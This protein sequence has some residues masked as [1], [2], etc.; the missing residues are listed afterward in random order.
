[1][2]GSMTTIADR[3]SLVEVALATAPPDLVLSNARLV[4]VL[5]R[6]ITLSDIA[7]KNGRI[8]AVAPAGDGNW[9]DCPRLDLGTR[10]VAPGFIDAH[11]HVESSMVTVAEYAKAAVAHGVTMI[12]ADPHEIGNVLGIAG[13]KLMF[14]EAKTVPLRVRLRVPGRIPAMPDWL[15]TSGAR[16]D[17]EGTRHL[18]DWPEAVCLAG[19]INPRLILTRDEEQFEKI[20]MAITRGM[21]VSGQS[22]GLLGANLNAFAAAGPEDSHVAYTAEEIVENQR[23][24]MRTVL[25]FRPHR[26][27]RTQFGRLARIISE[28]RLETRFL[29]FCTDD[30]YPHDVLDEGL[31]DMR[32]RLAIE[33]GFDPITAYQIASLNV[34]EGLRIDREYGAIAPGKMADLLV[35]DDFEKVAIAGVMINGEWVVRDGLYRGGERRFHYPPWSKQTMR[36]ARRLSPADMRVEV[37]HN[38]HTARVRAIAATSPK[39]EKE[40][41]LPVKEG[42]ILPDPD[43]AVSSIVVVERHKA[44]G[45]VGKGFVTGLFVK[46]G[47]IAST[48]SHDAHNLMVIGANHEDMAMAANHAIEAGGGYAVAIDGRLIFELALPVAGL[49]SEAPIET[50]ARQTRQLIDILVNQLGCPPAEK[51]LLRMNGLS[52]PNIPNYGFTDRGMI[53]TLGMEMKEPVIDQGGDIDRRPAA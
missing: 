5:T 4:N 23:V 31:I 26:L 17:V 24:G 33:E 6:E 36:V 35:L 44:S 51:L 39:S 48:V 32:V 7:I 19:D 29:Q 45:R 43:Q 40:F 11:V 49:M 30:V 13:M 9:L 52:L 27:D 50:V 46:R 16:V 8:A 25:A 10:H 21:T 14:D 22:P 12:A 47:A 18:M 41:V 34:A 15:E 42:V 2:E 1:M 37:S 20:E 28:R 3:K 38:A 53:Y